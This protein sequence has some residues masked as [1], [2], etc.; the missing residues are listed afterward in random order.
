MEGC[1]FTRNL[2]ISILELMIDAVTMDCGYR[3]R[4]DVISYD[5][6]KIQLFN[7]SENTFSIHRLFNPSVLWYYS[8]SRMI[9]R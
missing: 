7:I 4:Y 1:N 6:I 3:R 9:S 5:L 8:S 2:N